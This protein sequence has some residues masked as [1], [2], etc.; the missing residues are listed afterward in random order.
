M[1]EAIERNKRRSLILITVM[2]FVLVVLGYVI[3]AA[4]YAQVISSTGSLH[5]YVRYADAIGE[6]ENFAKLE[7]LGKDLKSGS[8]RP[9]FRDLHKG[10]AIGGGI[11][12][13]VWFVL[14]LTAL[15]HGNEVVLN[16]VRARRIEKEDAPKLWNIVEEMTIASGLGTMPRVYLI[17]DESPNAFAVG[18]K[19]ENAAVA[20]TSGLLKRLNRDEL[21]GVIAHEIAHI[22]N[23]DVRFLTIAA[24]MVGAILL[25]SDGFL[26]YLWYGG[27]R[28]TSSRRGGKA[29]IIMLAVAILVAVLAPIVARLL[30]LACS[31]KREYLADASAARFTR[32][33]SGLASALEKIA[34]NAAPAAK[35]NR[36]LAPLYIIN[37]SQKM[38]LTGLFSTHPP[39]EKRIAVLRGMGGAAGLADYEAAFKKINGPKQSCLSASMLENDESVTARSPTVEREPKREAVDRARQVGELLDRFANFIPIICACGVRIKVPPESRRDAVDCPRCGRRHDVPKASETQPQSSEA[40]V[41][42]LRFERKS[43]GWESFKCACGRVNQ[44]SPAFKAKFLRCKGC[45]RRIEIV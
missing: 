45:D 15:L 11:A 25:I 35:P 37:P 40:A 39:T 36:A 32:Y 8:D 19:P 1:W 24:V 13:I 21:Q 26:R 6:P 14:M 4:I 34:A 7:Q 22:R 5:F 38:A 16:S 3:G 44:V 29:Q 12:L 27:G 42:P 18:R 30:Y 10:G 31:R 17:E 9:S 33:P 41:A 28:R 2:G 23:L 43:G 20:V